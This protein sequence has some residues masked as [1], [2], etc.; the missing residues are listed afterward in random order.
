MYHVGNEF[1]RALSKDRFDMPSRV[2]IDELRISRVA[3]S[4]DWVKASNRVSKYCEMIFK[5]FAFGGGRGVSLT[6]PTM[7]RMRT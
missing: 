2:F 3:R 7:P 5:M 6:T 4:A 1:Y